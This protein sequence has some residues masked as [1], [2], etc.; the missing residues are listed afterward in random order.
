MIADTRLEAG[1]RLKENG[2][3][4]RGEPMYASVRK[5]RVEADRMEELMRRI[6]AG[7]VARIESSPGF[8]AYQAVDCGRD[9]TG[10]GLLITIS[11]FSDYEAAERSSHL[12]KEFVRD[13]LSD[14]RVEAVEAETGAV[15]VSRAASPML[16]P[17][18][19]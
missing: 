12:A 16:D 9:H 4:T 14:F 11:T 13:E 8:V 5:Y 6:D 10:G 2:R 7:F 15:K 19:A 18:H 17:A 3:S 1:C